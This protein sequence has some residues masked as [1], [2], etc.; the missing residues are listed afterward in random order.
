[1]TTPDQKVTRVI[2]ETVTKVDPKL[3]KRKAVFSNSLRGIITSVTARNAT[4]GPLP[5]A[6]LSVHTER[7][8]GNKTNAIKSTNKDSS[9]L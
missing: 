2:G 1:M 8:W 7:R 5:I 9:R 4:S 6:S 3:T